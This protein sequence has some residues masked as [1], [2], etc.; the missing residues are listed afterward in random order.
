MKSLSEKHWVRGSKDS[1]K[2]AYTFL[3]RSYEGRD[4][5]EE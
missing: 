5:E 4:E 1:V 2:K 3:R